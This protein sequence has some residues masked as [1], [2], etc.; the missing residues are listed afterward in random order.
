MLAQSITS[1]I[2]TF[3]ADLRKFYIKN[4][5]AKILNWTIK[6]MFEMMDYNKDFFEQLKKNNILGTK[7]YEEK[8]KWSRITIGTMNEM[9]QFIKA[10]E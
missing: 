3:K 6:T 10:L 8:G 7:F 5:Y 1:K 9:K 2:Y 4:G